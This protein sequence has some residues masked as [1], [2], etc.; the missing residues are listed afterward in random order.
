MLIC[1]LC[2][3]LLFAQENAKFKIRIKDFNENQLENPFCNLKNF[4]VQTLSQLNYQQ[5]QMPQ[6]SLTV[7]EGVV[8]SLGFISCFLFCDPRLGECYEDVYGQKMPEMFLKN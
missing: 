8:Q 1:M 3:S 5:V 7:C 4:P 2:F 6:D